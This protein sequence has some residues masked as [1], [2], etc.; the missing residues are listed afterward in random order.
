MQGMF[1]SQKTPTTCLVTTTKIL[2]KNIF[3]I[4]DLPST[5]LARSRNRPPQVERVWSPLGG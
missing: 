3:L 5:S 4:E 1:A 2:E